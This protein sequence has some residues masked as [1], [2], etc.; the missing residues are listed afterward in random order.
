MVSELWSAIEGVVKEEGLALFDLDEPS[1]GG[2]GGILRVYITQSDPS[3]ETKGSGVSFE[4]C[5]RVSR[6]LL[7]IDEQQGFI[8]AGCLLEVSSPGVNRRL[9]RPEHFAGAVGERIK[10]KFS[11]ENRTRSLLGTVQSWT[12]EELEIQDERG[13]E[14]VTISFSNIK[15]AHVEFSF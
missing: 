2:G 12:G 11:S 7:D 3:A 8:P 5:S 10:I 6:R 9:R 1:A 15:S 13:G 4:D 14:K